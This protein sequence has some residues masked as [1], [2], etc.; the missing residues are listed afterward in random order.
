MT[1]SKDERESALK[2][3]IKATIDL[4]QAANYMLK[5]DYDNCYTNLAA[6][7]VRIKDVLDKIES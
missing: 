6:V 4:N 3:I 5:S 2:E 1:L 7:M